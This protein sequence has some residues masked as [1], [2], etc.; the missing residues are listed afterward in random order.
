METHIITITFHECATRY[1]LNEADVRE[2]MELGLLHPAPDTPDAVY[3]EP[4]HVARLARLHHELELSKDSLEVVLAM[5]QRLEQ[6]HLELVRQRARVQ[7]LEGFLRGSG[8][9][10]DY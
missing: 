4:L 8:P 1:G 6:L 7:Q 2:F 5:R 3:E 9:L 10:L